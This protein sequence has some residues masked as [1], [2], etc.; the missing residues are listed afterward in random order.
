MHLRD[1]FG[2]VSLI[3]SSAGP[4]C[5][6][7]KEFRNLGRRGRVLIQGG[8]KL[9]CIIWALIDTHYRVKFGHRLSHIRL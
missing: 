4:R 8:T 3:Q 9:E 5:G 7:N 6:G 2:L 1:E